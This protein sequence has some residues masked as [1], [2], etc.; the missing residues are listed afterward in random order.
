[1]KVSTIEEMRELDKKAMQLGI[2]DELLMENAGHACYFVILN[3]IGV[4]GKKFIVFAGSGNNGG[5]GLMLSRKLH[6][7][8][9]NVKIYMVGDPAKYKGSAL[10]NYNIVKSI[11][12]PI[13]KAVV[14][15]ELIKE[16]EN[17]D[18]V[19][20]AMLGTGLKR[21]VEGLYKEVIDAINQHAKKVFSI[22]IPSGINGNNGMAMGTAVKADYTV[23]FGL[24][25]IGNLLYPGYEYCGNLYVSHISFPPSLYENIKVETND[26]IPLPERKKD[27]HKGSFGDVLF[28]AGATNYYGAPY[29]AA[30]SFLKAG[31]GYA[32]LA[33][34]ASIIPFIGAGG[35]E[36]VFIPME[37]R[38][39]GMALENEDALLEMASKVD[40]VVIGCGLS[41]NEGTKELVRRLV[42]KIDKP[43]LIDG[44]GLTAI[45][46]DEECVIKRKAIAVLT[47]HPGEMARISKKS[48]DDILANKIDVAIEEAKKLKSIIVLKGAHTIIAYPDGRAFINMTGNS[49]MATAGS[50][51]VLA[52]VIAAMYGIGFSIDNAARMGVFI[53]GL[54]GDIAAMKKGEDGITARDI[55]ENLPDAMKM[56]R[57]DFEGIAKKYEIKVV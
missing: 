46:E 39:G 10:M 26:P 15:E 25:K 11:G 14:N 42:E 20:D 40:M 55:M 4:K 53:H 7:S 38:D 31:G 22:D 9:G 17:A 21:E 51:D 29:F 30:R 28:I 19:I 44:D 37:E 32:R 27:G 1:M 50:G 45:S 33:A 56:M 18:V 34:P 57:E 43:V 16:I 48:I 52:G 5:D 49:G 2:K 8:G 3:E 6:S 54:S 47:P 36:I 41:L 13:E 24:P 35:S 23:T 12:I